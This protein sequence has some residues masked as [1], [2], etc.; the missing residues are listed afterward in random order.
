MNISKFSFYFRNFCEIHWRNLH[1]SPGFLTWFRRKI[2]NFVPEYLRNS[3]S[4][5][6]KK[7]TALKEPTKYFLESLS[8]ISWIF[9]SR[10][11][12]SRIT[13]KSLKFSKNMKSTHFLKKL[14]FHGRTVL[15]QFFQYLGIYSKNF[16]FSKNIF[17]MSQVITFFD[18]KNKK[19]LL[20]FPQKNYRF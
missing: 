2:L 14:T 3:L 12:H 20:V 8:K 16:S 4:K 19:N 7:P 6:K 17:S 5:S 18:Y 9:K 11:S 15:T 1:L 13:K 10:Q